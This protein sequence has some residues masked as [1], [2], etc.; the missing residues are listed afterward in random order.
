VADNCYV[1]EPCGHV[2]WA[3]DEDIV[4]TAPE[5]YLSGRWVSDACLGQATSVRLLTT[6]PYSVD[7]FDVVLMDPAPRATAT[8]YTPGAREA[9]YLFPPMRMIAVL[10]GARVEDWISLLAPDSAEVATSPRPKTWL[11]TTLYSQDVQDAVERESFEIQDGEIYQS[12]FP[13]SI[14]RASFELPSGSLVQVYFPH[15]V[16]IVQKVGRQSFDLPS[17]NLGATYFPHYLD[18][19]VNNIERVSFELPSGSLYQSYWPVEI[20]VDTDSVKRASFELPT[21]TLETV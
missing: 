1:C 10:Y 7:G 13:E 21:G 12:E 9:V 17:G 16:E 2:V 20:T 6:R 8:A 3:V 19:G 15:T 4:W 5:H 14:W 11:T 18:A